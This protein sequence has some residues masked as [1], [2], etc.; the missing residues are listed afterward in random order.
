MEIPLD[1]DDRRFRD[2]V[3]DFLAREMPRDWPHP[4][5][6]GSF[7]ITDEEFPRLRAWQRKLFDAR[8]IGITWPSE[9]G[10]R[11]APPHH[12]AILQDEMVRA[13][14]PPT[15]NLLGI[16]LCGPALLHYGSP[17]QKSRYLAKML[18]G[19]EVW[20]QGYS[21]PGSGSDLASLRTT[22]VLRGDDWIV[23]GQKVW[24]TDGKVADWMFCL[25]R[26]DQQAPKHKGIGFLLI[27]MK[28]PG[29]EVRPL[30]QIT[31]GTEF[32]E[33]FFTDVAVPRANMVGQP[34]QGWLIANTVLGYERGTQALAAAATFGSDLGRLADE[35]RRDG[36]DADPRA[37]QQ[38][39]QLRI[40][41]AILRLLGLRVLAGLREG[42][43]PGSEASM[44]KLFKSELEQR[45]Y[46][47]AVD[48]QGPRGAVWAG[49]HAV[50]D[51]HWHWRMLWSRAGTIYAGTSEVQRN[52]IAQRVL[53][54]PRD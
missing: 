21:E 27:D 28:S 11:D 43:A 19:E 24:T 25:V 8:M 48:R 7:E 29:V 34:T 41:H 4:P 14:A 53:G 2:E 46:G 54:L 15:I 39:A 22:A 1:E 5:G 13:G 16:S 31:G 49:E 32:C 42:R 35:M 50:D 17:E 45:L 23:N 40:D 30:R 18:S 44:I 51:G 52:I 3:R 6:T 26:S 12:D 10:G 38:M 33:V 9:Y 37:R 20:C 36:A 47:F